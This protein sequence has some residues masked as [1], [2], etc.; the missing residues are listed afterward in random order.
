MQR[1]ILSRLYS[2]MSFSLQ[3]SNAKPSDRCRI[4]KWNS[5]RSPAHAT[6]AG[7]C[8]SYF[9]FILL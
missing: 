7:Y 5:F 1:Q 6:A 3:Q 4:G 8:H 2:M 9:L